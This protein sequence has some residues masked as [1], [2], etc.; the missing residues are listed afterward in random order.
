MSFE[1][2]LSL[3]QRT[4][5]IDSVRWVTIGVFVGMILSKISASQNFTKKDAAKCFV[6]SRMRSSNDQEVKYYITNLMHLNMADFLEVR[7]IS[8]G[9]TKKIS[10]SSWLVLECRQALCRVSHIKPLPTDQYL[11][12]YFGSSL[13]KYRHAVHAKKLPKGVKGMY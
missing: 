5:I 11:R 4:S 12:D 7:K 6:M 9:L 13:A 8:N 2:W 1:G 3:L 10:S